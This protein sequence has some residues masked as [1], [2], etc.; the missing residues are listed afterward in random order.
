MCPS[1][2][3]SVKVAC[4]FFAKGCKIGTALDSIGKTW[5]DKMSSDAP[6]RT[7]EKPMS[8][9]K[10]KRSAWSVF[11]RIQGECLRRSVTAFLMYMF[12]SILM[13]VAQA[14]NDGTTALEIVLGSICCLGGMAFNAHLCFHFGKNHYDFYLTGCMHR[15]NAVFGIDSMGSHPVH[16]EYRPWKGFLIGFYA[17]L[18]AMIF[19]AF[20]GALNPAGVEATDTGYAAI[21]ILSAFAG[22]AIIPLTWIRDLAGMEYISYY[23]SIAFCIIPIVVSGVFYILGAMSR[24]REK[25]EEA[26]LQSEV[27]RAGEE[28]KQEVRRVQTEEQR[29]KTLQ[30]KK[31]K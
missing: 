26:N 8:S 7:G 18:F 17:A 27:L 20:A 25:E 23:W 19:G 31:K 16:R 2:P 21:I 4:Y 10:K 1:T 22:W 12:M 6:R 5:Y 24:K 29:K 30:S 13:I 9:D 15:R 14:I 3:S 28:A 11:W